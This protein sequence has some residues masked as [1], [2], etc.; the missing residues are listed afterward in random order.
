MSMR[1]QGKVAVVIGG[2]SGIGRAAALG[3]AAE[4]AKVV[5]TGRDP[6]TLAAVEKELGAGSLAI[7]SDIGDL[8]SL[9]AAYA[10]VKARHGHI[11]VLFVNAG[12]GTFAPIPE[13]TPERWDEVHAVNLKGCFFA[14]Q[15]ALPLMADG[16]AIVFTG[17]IGSVLAVP[18]NVIYA[19]AKSGLRAAARIFAVELLPRRIRVNMV[20]PGPTETPLIN[21]NVGMSPDAVNALR[22]RMIANTPMRRMGEPEE[23]AR[24]VLFLSS[25]EASFI[26]GVDLFVDGGVVEL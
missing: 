26:T 19:A 2:N 8:A 15:K 25:D 3:Y 16:G 23:V 20:S 13:V 5:V 18:G 24:A 9:D 11:D 1:F 4:G 10:A 12:I 7:R 17:S 21:R 22:E 14:A 6:A